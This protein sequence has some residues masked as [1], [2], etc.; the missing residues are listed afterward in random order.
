MLDDCGQERESVEGEMRFSTRPIYFFSTFKSHLSRCFQTV[1]RKNPKKRTA[2]QCAQPVCWR[3]G[4]ISVIAQFLLL[5]RRRSSK[6]SQFVCYHFFSFS[7][8]ALSFF[9]K[10]LEDSSHLN[11]SV[12]IQKANGMFSESKCVQTCDGAAFW[13]NGIQT[14]SFGG[15]SCKTTNIFADIML[16]FHQSKKRKKNKKQKH[17]VNLPEDPPVCISSSL[18]FF[19]GWQ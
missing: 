8:F 18:V 19:F 13:G 12:I 16:L 3:F 14:A 10:N 4:S 5:P 15:F 1:C 9:L 11:E 2:I 17:I 6:C 7:V